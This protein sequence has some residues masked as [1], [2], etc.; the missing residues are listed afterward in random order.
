M[1]VVGRASVGAMFNCRVDGAQ[2][3]RRQSHQAFGAP[4]QSAV[5]VLQ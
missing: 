4:M 2:R 3:H 1:A 5:L